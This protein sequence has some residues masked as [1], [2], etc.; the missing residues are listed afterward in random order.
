MVRDDLLV[1]VLCP[2][3]GI[4]GP[5]GTV[6]GNRNHVLEASR[7]SIHSGRRREDNVGD[8]VLGHRAEQAHGAVCVDAVVFQRNLA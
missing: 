7:V 5:E 8:L 2:S 3:V 1:E 4:R 6:F